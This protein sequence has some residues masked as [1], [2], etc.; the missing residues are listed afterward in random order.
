MSPDLESSLLAL[1]ADPVVERDLLEGSSVFGGHYADWEG[2]RRLI[3]SAINQSGSLLDIGCANG[4]LLFCLVHWTSHTLEPYGIDVDESRLDAAQHLFDAHKAHFVRLPVGGLGPQAL[5]TAGL[6]LTYDFVYWN[7]WDNLDFQDAWAADYLE[8][9]FRCV[10]AGGRLILGFYDLD[11]D[12]TERKVKFVIGRLGT[13]TGRLG[14]VGHNVMVI[15]WDL[16][17]GTGA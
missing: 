13:P 11:L 17:V 4:F 9:V 12:A 3:A 6:P 15:W 7:V 16:A 10:R 14:P 2:D 5:S 8:R 1:M